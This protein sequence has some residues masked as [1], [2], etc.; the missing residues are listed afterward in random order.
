MN[1]I[2]CKR[3]RKYVTVKDCYIQKSGERKGRITHKLRKCKKSK[4]KK[5]LWD[6]Y[7]N[8]K[9]IIEMQKWFLK[10]EEKI[11]A[12]NR[13]FGRINIEKLSDGYVRQIL[14]DKGFTKEQLNNNKE[15]IETQKIIIK[16]KRLCKT[17]Q[18]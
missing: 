15:I 18:N 3:C 16:T 6:D 17:L 11:K 2:Y 13:N 14:I 5:L 7:L 1:L 4:C 8:P 10:N 9:V 12:Y